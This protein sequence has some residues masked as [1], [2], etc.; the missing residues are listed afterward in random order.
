MNKFKKSVLKNISRIVSIV[1]CFAILAGIVEWNLFLSTDAGVVAY[2]DTFSSEARDSIEF[3]PLD[4]TITLDYQGGERTVGEQ[5]LTSDS[6]K[7]T[8]NN[9][10][11]VNVPEREGY[12]FYGFFSGKN[13]DGVK[14]FDEYGDMSDDVSFTVDTPHT[15]Y[16]AWV[17]LS[18]GVIHVDDG[19]I[20]VNSISGQKYTQYKS[21][22]LDIEKLIELRYSH[23]QVNLDINMRAENKGAGREIRLQLGSSSVW[24][25]TGIDLENT[26]WQHY[27]Y[28]KTLDISNFSNNSNFRLA[29]NQDGGYTWSFANW[30][31]SDACVYFTAIDQEPKDSITTSTQ[32]L[33]TDTYI[34]DE[35]KNDYGN[36]G[37]D[38]T[39]ANNGA[40]HPLKSNY[41]SY[42]LRYNGGTLLKDD[43]N[44]GY[45]S[46]DKFDGSSTPSIQVLLK[47]NFP[48]TENINGTKWN[49]DYSSYSGTVNGISGAGT[50]GTGVLLVTKSKDGKDYTWENPYSGTA[51][52]SFHTSDFV[53]NYSPS[54]YN[55]E[56]GTGFQLGPV[57]KRDDDGN[58][59]Y[60]YNDDG[61]KTG[62]EYVKN[63]DNYVYGEEYVPIDGYLPIYQPSGEDLKQGIYIKILFAYQLSY[64]SYKDWWEELW[65]GFI[66][67]TKVWHYVNVVEETSLYISNSRAEI[68]FQNMN[69]SSSNEDEKVESNNTTSELIRRFGNV[70]DG[71]SVNDGFKVNYN[72]NNYDVRY[73]KNNSGLN[74]N[75]NDPVY[76]GRIFMEPGKYE[77]VITPK[78]GEP[79]RKTIYINDRGLAQNLN[80][81][82][83][84]NLI[85]EGSA[86]MFS[87]TSEVPVYK[88]GKVS[89]HTN[90]V[91]ANHMPICGRIG[92]YTETLSKAEFETKY[93]YLEDTTAM[94]AFNSAYFKQAA[95]IEV[96]S[97]YVS[98][99][100]D[101]FTSYRVRVEAGYTPVDGDG[102]EEYGEP[103]TVNGVTY[104]GT[105]YGSVELDD[106]RV[107]VGTIDGYDIYRIVAS[108]SGDRTAV[109]GSVLTESGNYLA[110][111]AN[112]GRY[113]DDNEQASG[114]VYVFIFR[115]ML[116]DEDYLPS[117]NE[118]TLSSTLGISDY[119]SRFYGVK[120]PNS[121]TGKV[122]TFVYYDEAS[123]YNTAYEYARS[124][125]TVSG[126]GYL[127]RGKYYADR[128][129]VQSAVNAYS[130]SEELVS[131]SYFDYSDIATYLIYGGDPT[132]VLTS[133]KVT[134][135]V[136]VF[137]SSTS[138]YNVAAGLPFL[139][140]RKYNYL[141]EN[142]EIKS[143]V[144]HVKFV[145]VADYES[146]SVELIYE[147]KKTSY[148]IIPYGADAESYLS[149]K[150][151]P[152]GKYKIVEKNA[153]G[154]NIYYA[155]Y[156][157]PG[158]NLTNIET[159]RVYNSFS[160]TPILNKKYANV[161]FTA[162]SFLIKSA[163]NAHDPYGIVK[164]S[165]TAGEERIYQLAEV[166][167][168]K[169]DTSGEW[170]V[171]LIDRL[172]NTVDFYINIYTPSKICELTLIDNGTVTKQFVSNGERFELPEPLNSSPSYDFIGW[173]S[174]DGKI[175]NGT[176]IIG[177]TEDTTLTALYRFK[178]STVLVYDGILIESYKTK[179]AETLVLPSNLS[180][181]GLEF[182]GYK[183][184]LDGEERF[185][186]GQLNSVPNVS[187]LRLDAVY[188][189]KATAI[190]VTSGQSLEILNK[191]GYT[192]YGWGTATRGA[193]ANIFTDGVAD[194]E[195]AGSL[196]LYAMYIADEGNGV[197]IGGA[198]STGTNFISGLGSLLYSSV[199]NGSL[200]VPF[201]VLIMLAVIAVLS[202]KKAVR[203][204]NT[205]VAVASV[206][207]PS[208]E[209]I[210]YEA[211]LSASSA[212]SIR[213]I[214]R[215]DFKNFHKSLK[216]RTVVLTAVSL[217]MAVIF[218]FFAIDNLL[219]SVSTSIRLN[220]YAATFSQSYES[221][222]NSRATFVSE[223]DDF[224]AEETF[225]FS[226]VALDLNELGYDTF[227]AVVTKSNGENVRG[228]GFTD[229]TYIGERDDLEYYKAGFI[230]YT[231]ELPF[232]ATDFADSKISEYVEENEID[233][234]DPEYTF[235]LKL[236][237]DVW[238]DHYIAFEQYVT[239]AVDGYRIT[240]IASDDEPDNY[241]YELGFLYNYDKGEVIYDPDLGTEFDKSGYSLAIAADH[242]KLIEAYRTIIDYQNT[243][244]VTVD[245]ITFTVIDVSAINEYVLHGQDE[246]FLGI[247]S[248]QIAF[249]ESQITNT[250]FY[251]IDGVTGQISV[252]EIPEITT[253][254]SATI[255][256]ILNVVLNVAMIVGGIIIC[257][258][259][260]GFGLGLGL[261][262]GGVF[263]LVAQYFQDEIGQ[264]F[265]SI[266]GTKGTQAL[267]GGMSVTMGAVTINI[268]TKLI[269]K[270]GW[271]TA[272]GVV[273]IIIGTLL[274]TFGL[275]ELTEVV[276]N[277]NIIKEWTGISDAAY[278]N[279]YRALGY[280]ATVIIVVYSTLTK[281][282]K[283]V[284]EKNAA[285][286]AGMTVKEYRRAQKEITRIIKENS[287]EKAL[288]DKTLTKKI[289]DN[290]I[291]PAHDNKTWKMVSSL[292]DFDAAGN[293][294][295]REQLIQNGGS[296]YIVNRNNP[297]IY[298]KVT[299]GLVDFS[300]HMPNSSAFIE[301]PDISICS[302]SNRMNIFDKM[303]AD[304]LANTPGISIPKQLNGNIS[305]DA[306]RNFRETY[307]Y[308][309]HEDITG[310]VML[311][312]HSLHSSSW[313]GISHIGLH[314]MAI[315]NESAK[316]I[317]NAVKKL[318]E[319]GLK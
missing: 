111:F 123:A 103:Q 43:S 109:S 236:K 9:K 196:T 76:D 216:L 135:D 239:Y 77:F 180:R 52:T 155:I 233:S 178:E 191:S 84:G 316:D 115:F 143:A 15:L 27:Y 74:D 293:G 295:S 3:V 114:D 197:G 138:G 170:T 296:G 81:Y 25:R 97:N 292:D 127:F 133:D 69:F 230:S 319:M 60:T 213:K 30:Q 95:R 176:F 134:H 182:Y 223:D 119:E 29:L 44:Y 245:S 162:N 234:F 78:V 200:F 144:N 266:L 145:Q 315:G 240:Y 49:I 169:I 17:K 31:F 250:S 41:V 247:S 122:V 151:A 297:E 283:L 48:K 279:L 154:E 158:D 160:Q 88:S 221:Y 107:I 224:N 39:K 274:A 243:N 110:E 90:N 299:N 156:L 306:I 300:P 211:S 53:N 51:T 305:A 132:T 10:T 232:S 282:Y 50:V 72:G 253:D 163:E 267:G 149:G 285:A 86:R 5:T 229:W 217:M 93:G 99:P 258:T 13:G 150:N 136:F 231:D 301:P 206:K 179:P 62:Y 185:C 249:V 14:Y 201:A 106:G 113:F 94:K 157:K 120:I 8:S 59:V 75:V 226:L 314:A 36:C 104:I 172:G 34:F 260:V 192:F 22:G 85:E 1:L 61:Q 190:A 46:E 187:E 193:N 91:D 284:D 102:F 186:I 161:A 20:N 270:T 257:C 264:I 262:A 45:I 171:S 100:D 23:I 252:L 131:I 278:A 89:W 87:Q 58:I 271:G 208:D 118:L 82:F 242:E 66:S 126:D 251:Y 318:K 168:I 108:K 6:L 303:Y 129:S 199:N 188:L 276:F 302:K 117:I 130:K 263:G 310:R 67:E 275:S 304:K 147:D 218:S 146:E 2:A 212:P 56:A 204:L 309:W 312:P 152:S 21:V 35:S 265:N 308:V 37:Y 241:L 207:S 268:G 128:A 256:N 287:Y 141:D 167:N 228:I 139:N 101:G 281:Y 26:E 291:Y 225:L 205:S 177:F 92:I 311:I 18:S 235:E 237:E 175:Y 65:D 222:E 19:A 261:A 57:I 194:F 33:K 79:K 290:N 246:T 210:C 238:A 105:I 259:G 227:E 203:E 166:D 71:D 307:N 313:S 184:V 63:N 40:T 248:E 96:D 32:S 124:L 288:E 125:V 116:S 317:Y 83:S 4:Y 244:G 165:N 38:I 80:Y 42:F 137:D 254:N 255:W 209:N 183:Y 174:S 214:R 153:Y 294:I 98:T 16:A 55:G 112:N 54:I 68:L 195:G 198:L 148:G 189:D 142:G 280:A 286:E 12:V 202:K 272:A 47:Y 70:N 159:T 7:V 73:S 24:E 269:G 298:V 289:V 277:Y 220:A 11:Y 173:E 28:A 64:Y 164:I 121:A 215:G 219:G 181:P 140:D 273:C